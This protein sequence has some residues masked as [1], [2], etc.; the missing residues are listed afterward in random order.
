[1]ALSAFKAQVAKE[2]LVQTL[3][4]FHEVHS[5]QIGV[6]KARLKRMALPTVSESLVFKLINELIADE[7]IKQTRGW[8]HMPQHGLVFDTEQQQIWQ[9]IAPLFPRAEAW[10]SP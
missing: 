5:D 6:G 3:E 9:Q 10:W 1:M 7:R 4:D 2:R 8:L